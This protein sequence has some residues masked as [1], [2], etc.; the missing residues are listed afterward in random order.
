MRSRAL[1]FL[2]PNDQNALPNIGLGAFSPSSL[3]D[4][5]R[6][7]VMFALQSLHDAKSGSIGIQF[8]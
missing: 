5:H 7:K 2:E 3:R 4:S 8:P 1:N 6:N